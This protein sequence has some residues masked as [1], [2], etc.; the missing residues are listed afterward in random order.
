MNQSELIITIALRF[1][2]TKDDTTRV[3]D[4][5]VKTA[6]HE[7]AVGGEIRLLGFG[8]FKPVHRA[9]RVGTSP[10]TGEKIQIAAQASV[11]FRPSKE[12]KDELNPV[13]LTGARRR[14]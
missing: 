12:L 1:A 8:T 3:I 7:L 2:L 5:F 9:A 6:R 13:R 14:T 11:K 4:A 10:Q